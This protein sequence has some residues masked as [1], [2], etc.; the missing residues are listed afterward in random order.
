MAG[1]PSRFLYISRTN[2]EKILSD[3]N[4]DA[5]ADGG[6]GV[7]EQNDLID[8][9]TGDLEAD[10]VERFIVP[11]QALNGEFKNAPVY[12]QQKVLNALKSKIRQII[13]SDKQKNIVID[14]TERYIDLKLKEY[15]DHIKDLLN[16][17]RDFKMKLQK[18][19]SDTALQ[20]VQT[21]GVARPSTK[22][23]TELVDDEEGFVF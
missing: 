5:T 7:I 3:L 17:K 19:A 21:I 1:N 4:V 2:F 10:L 13:G 14:S 11:L 20:P 16:H 22:R 9:S 6:Y 8:R 12:S 23:T 18:F 15:K